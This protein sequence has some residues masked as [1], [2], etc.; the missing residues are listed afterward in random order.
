M[1]AASHPIPP[2]AKSSGVPLADHTRHVEAQ[3]DEYFAAR[4]FVPRKYRLL[5]GGQD[6]EALVRVAVR[7]HD[8]GKRHQKWQCACRL[9]YEEFKRTGKSGNHL[10]DAGLRHEMASLE[11]IRRSGQELPLCVRAAIGAHHGKLSR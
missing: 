7:W 10:R 1:T 11:F 2:L 3:A 4:P 5:T 8:E 9:D 6:L